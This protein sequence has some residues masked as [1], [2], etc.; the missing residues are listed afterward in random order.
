MTCIHEG[1]SLDP[2][3]TRNMDRQVH[4]SPMVLVPVIDWSLSLIPVCTISLCKV[5][6]CD[7]QK[8][9]WFARKDC[10]SGQCGEWSYI[11]FID[12]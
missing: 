4:V 6:F 12:E 10:R 2:S 11:A 3:A 1:I 8:S 5:T 7:S 9:K